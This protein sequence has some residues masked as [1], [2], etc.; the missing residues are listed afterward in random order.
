MTLYVVIYID[1][2][3]LYIISIN[4]EGDMLTDQRL[5]RLCRAIIND[6]VNGDEFGNMLVEAGVRLDDLK[7]KEWDVAN[8]LLKKSDAIRHASG[9]KDN[10]IIH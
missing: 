10:K 7:E 4:K 8:N 2:M 9:G 3:K 6:D 1:Y 5:I